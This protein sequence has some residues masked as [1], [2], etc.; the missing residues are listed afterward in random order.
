MVYELLWYDS[1]LHNV[2]NLLRCC[3]KEQEK[4]NVVE[5]TLSE[6]LPPSQLSREKKVSSLFYFSKLLLFRKFPPFFRDNE[7]KKEKSCSFSRTR[8]PTLK[9]NYIFSP[10]HK[11][12]FSDCFFHF[13]FYRIHLVCF[14]TFFIF[15][16]AIAHEFF[17][18]FSF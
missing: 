16:F 2:H 15:P 11:Q 8:T 5:L 3:L 18:F 13:S 12:N 10:F 9:Y 1:N 17:P 4:E 7:K 14:E 6:C